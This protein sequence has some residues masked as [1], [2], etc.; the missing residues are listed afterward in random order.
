MLAGNLLALLQQNVKR[1]LAYSSIAHW[2]TSPWL[3]SPPAGG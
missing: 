2:A 3:S 1:L